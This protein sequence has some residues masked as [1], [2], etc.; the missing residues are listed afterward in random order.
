MV[1]QTVTT[2]R[3]TRDVNRVSSSA[4]TID[5]TANPLECVQATPST[6]RTGGACR[7]AREASS[8]SISGSTRFVKSGNALPVPEINLGRYSRRVFRSKPRSSTRCLKT[9]QALNFGTWSK[10]AT[11]RSDGWQ[12]SS[13]ASFDNSARATLHVP[14][15]ETATVS[16]VAVNTHA[17]RCRDLRPASGSPRRR[18]AKF[19]SASPVRPGNCWSITIPREAI[20][21][22]PSSIWI[23]SGEAP[24]ADNEPTRCTDGQKDEL[25]QC[26]ATKVTKERRKREGSVNSLRVSLRLFVPSWLPLSVFICVHLWF[27]SSFAPNDRSR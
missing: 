13:A 20:V 24:R 11:A 1:Q 9:L 7:I 25:T 18:S 5:G 4:S 15:S 16:S 19:R 22:A 10:V 12:S 27:H 26:R 3:I 23:A 14:N 21:S 2:M 8:R 6:K 17:D